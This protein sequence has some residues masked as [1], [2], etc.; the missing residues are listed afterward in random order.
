MMVGL[1]ERHDERL[2]QDLR[3]SD[4]RNTFESQYLAILPVAKSDKGESDIL[5]N[6]TKLTHLHQSA[7]A[8]YSMSPKTIRLNNKTSTCDSTNRS[9]LS[10]PGTNIRSQKMCW[11]CQPRR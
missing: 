10:A 6:P 4:M 5:A 11:R 2:L 1:T 8:K 3:V 7:L 9:G